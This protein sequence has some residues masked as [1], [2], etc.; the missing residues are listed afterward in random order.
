MAIKFNNQY[1]DTF[2][3]PDVSIREEVA[4]VP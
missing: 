1:G 4:I 3:I 2:K